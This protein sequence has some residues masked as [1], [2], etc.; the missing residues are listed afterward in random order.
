MKSF[1]LLLFSYSRVVIFQQCSIRCLIEEIFLVAHGVKEGMDDA[2]DTAVADQ[3][4]VFPLAALAQ[5]VQERIDARGD[6]HVRF[7]AGITG[8][9]ATF[10]GEKAGVKAVFSFENA[11]ILLDEAGLDPDRK[12]AL[13]GGEGGGMA[14]T[15]QRRAQNRGEVDL[16][17]GERQGFGLL[18][19]GFGQGDVGQAADAIFDVPGG[20]P[21][22]GDE[23]RHGESSF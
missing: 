7:A 13:L 21:M 15:G 11:V 8:S 19:A 18:Y 16:L 14:C 6:V 20:L 5:L 22:A 12:A 17:G 23:Q 10:V 9:E 1:L 2:A 3:K 4:D